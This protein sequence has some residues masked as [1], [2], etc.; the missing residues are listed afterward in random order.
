MSVTTYKSHK[1]K[2][3]AFIFSR[4]QTWYLEC[5]SWISVIIFSLYFSLIRV[6]WKQNLRC[7]INWESFERN[8][9]DDK[10]KYPEFRKLKIYSKNEMINWMQYFEPSV[11]T[12]ATTHLES[13]RSGGTLPI[14]KNLLLLSFDNLNRKI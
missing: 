5:H 3:V 7:E 11:S 4:K 13:L 12:G 1:Q 2:I 8:W 14:G 10:K 9:K 6:L